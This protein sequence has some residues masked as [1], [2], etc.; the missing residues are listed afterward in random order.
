MKEVK[1]V[2]VVAEENTEAI[3]TTEEKVGIVKKVG[4][5]VKAN[6]KKGVVLVAVGVG[7]Y[8]LGARAAK[9]GDDDVE[10]FDVIDTDDYV[11]EDAK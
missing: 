3:A 1:N 9:S 5:F 11:I 4:K 6:W 7:S 10:E 2:E 8:L